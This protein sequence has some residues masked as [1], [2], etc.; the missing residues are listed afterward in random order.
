[1]AVLLKQSIL[2]TLFNIAWYWRGGDYWKW[3]LL[4]QMTPGGDDVGEV[5]EY[6]FGFQ[7]AWYSDDLMLFICFLNRIFRKTLK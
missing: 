2:P 7:G 1:M 6:M 5:S 4:G 3:G